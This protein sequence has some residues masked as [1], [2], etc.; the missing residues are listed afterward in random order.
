MESPIKSVWGNIVHT[1]EQIDDKSISKHLKAVESG[2]VSREID[3][4]D[5]PLPVIGP[6]VNLDDKVICLQETYLEHLWSFIYSVFVIY[7]EGVQQRVSSSS[8]TGEIQF[9]TEIL[10]RARALYFWSISLSEEKT[11]WPDGLPKPNIY[12]NDSEKKYSEK[13][14]N[15]FQYAVAYVLFHEFCHLTQK[16]DSYRL[17]RN[18]GGV[19]SSDYAELIQMENEADEF[20]FNMMIS[21]YTEKVN[22]VVA[23][24]FVKCSSL[25]LT[26]QPEGIKQFKHPDLDSR[27]HVA[28]ERMNFESEGYEDYCWYLCCMAIHFYMVKHNYDYK[29]TACETPKECFFSL[30]EELEKIKSGLA[31]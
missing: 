10:K 8:F 25:L 16:H 26:K 5:R 7:E 3:Y 30:L 13:V 2:L 15:I 31:T 11:D 19:G 1:F 14:N 18:S 29:K 6:S 20:A 12:L 9:D 27:M 4:D 17:S 23:I 24:L 28:L 21:P 22:R